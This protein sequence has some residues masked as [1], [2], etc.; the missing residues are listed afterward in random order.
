[1]SALGCVLS[2]LLL[3]TIANDQSSLGSTS[4]AARLLV[5]RLAANTE[6]DGLRPLADVGGQA[7]RGLDSELLRAAF[8]GKRTVFIGDSTT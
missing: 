5:D 4:M 6:V 1:M 3:M 8:R 2:T 7:F